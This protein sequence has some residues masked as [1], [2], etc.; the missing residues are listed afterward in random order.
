MCRISRKS[1]TARNLMS[2]KN[3]FVI[4][5]VVAKLKPSLD[6]LAL[7]TD[8]WPRLAWSQNGMIFA[9]SPKKKIADTVSFYQEACLFLA[10]RKRIEPR[11]L[12]FD[13]HPYFECRRQAAGLQKS[14]F[15]ESRLAP[16]F[17]HVAHAALFAAETGLRKNF[18]ALAW[19]GTGFGAD[20]KV[21]GGEF[22]VYQDKRFRRAAHFSY[23]YLPGSDKAILEPWRVAFAVLYR[24]CGEKIFSL[25]LRF[26]KGRSRP[27]LRLLIEMMKKDFYS[28]Q[29]SSVGRLFDAVA[30]MLM[31]PSPMALEAC[32]DEG[33][34]KGAYSFEIEEAAGS[35]V[36]NP[37]L[38]FAQIIDD[39]NEKVPRNDIA[40]KFH[41]ALAESACVTALLLRK[42]FGI[43]RIYCSGGVFMNDVLRR[44]LSRALTS[45]AFEVIF[46][47]KE[48]T[49]DAGIAL[50]QVA[51]C[52]IGEQLKCA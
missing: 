46:A 11:F 48:L 42:K 44:E 30:S 6:I 33:R 8:T 2:A 15:P 16:V 32:A 45:E 13:P 10:R 23:Q 27:S 37:D 3:S 7:G 22:L 29:T 50:G 19:D 21:W 1:P 39:M 31:L 20:G 4:E 51:A 35:Y 34:A 47:P 18:I 38:L 9:L 5:A 14:F 26:L 17:H 49:T 24:I 28:P 43:S 52:E 36:V 25:N 40:L 41:R 12:A